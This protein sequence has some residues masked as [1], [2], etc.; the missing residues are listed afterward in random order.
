MSY[1][2]AKISIHPAEKIQIILLLAKKVIVLKI[3]SDF[4]DIFLKKS[5]AELF[6]YN[7]I[8]QYI[9]KLK[10]KNNYFKN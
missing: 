10:I 2:K 6:K 9:R 8:N 4:T 7:N 1:L 3:Y 5:V